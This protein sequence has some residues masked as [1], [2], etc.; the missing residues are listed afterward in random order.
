MDLAGKLNQP[1]NPE[2]SSLTNMLARRVQKSTETSTEE[3]ITNQIAALQDHFILCGGGRTAVH[4]IERFWHTDTQV[5][6]IEHDSEVIAKIQTVAAQHNRNL[7]YVQGDATEDE[8]LE[9]AGISRAEGL[10]SVLQDDKDNLFVILT[11]RSLNPKMKLITRVD[12]EQR[13]REKMLKAGADRVISTS[14]IGGLRIASEVIRPA[15]V[16]FLDQM[17]T[18]KDKEKTLRFT[19]IPLGKIKT[20]E[21]AE[22][23]RADNHA[24]NDN[25][26]VVDIGKH[27]GLLVVAVK[28]RDVKLM[29]DQEDDLFHLKRQYRFAPRGDMEL[30]SSD[31][32]VVIGTQ[33]KLDEVTGQG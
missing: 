8:V 1:N 17:L 9:Q 12:D 26:K 32:L 20:P 33:D 6:L 19:E 23:I 31:I 13:N 18:A 14:T 4:I 24:N 16:E 11:A 2:N 10:I 5:V 22:K 27:T 28:T 3:E 21:L 7:L 25:L 29:P 30:H 15:V